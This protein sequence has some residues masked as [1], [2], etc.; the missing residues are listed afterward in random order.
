MTESIEN[1]IE[2]VKLKIGGQEIVKMTGGATGDLKKWGLVTANSRTKYDETQNPQIQN[3]QPLH[4]WFCDYW[5]AS[6]PLCALSYHDVTVEIKW[7]GTPSTSTEAWAN[8]IW[9]D[10]NEREHFVKSEKLMYL[11]D[12]WQNSDPI[13]NDT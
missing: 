6:L 5:T 3:I 2:Y 11:V 8:M 9:L 4:F 1:Q 10:N 7:S 13:S 12:Q